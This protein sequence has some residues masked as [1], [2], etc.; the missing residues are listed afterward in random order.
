MGL[1]PILAGEASHRARDCSGCL[2]RVGVPASAGLRLPNRL[3]PG[4]QPRSA[5]MLDSVL[6]QADD[7]RGVLTSEAETVGQGVASPDLARP[8]GDVV[9]VAVRVGLLVV[10]RR[11]Q[12]APLK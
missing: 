10:D 5:R 12:H 1:Y 6:E 7:Q 9:E 2:G 8:V 4:L 11:R 3:K